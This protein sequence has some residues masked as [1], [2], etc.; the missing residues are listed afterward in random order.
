LSSEVVNIS[1]YYTQIEEYNRVFGDNINLYIIDFDDLVEKES[2]TVKKCLDFM[3][4]DSSF[5]SR[6]AG[7]T[8]NETRTTL[9][10]VALGKLR[11]MA[12]TDK[13]FQGRRRRKIQAMV[14]SLLPLVRHLSPASDKIR[15]SSSERKEII[16]L[17]AED[18]RS[19]QSEHGFDTGKW[20]F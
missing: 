16:D 4:L 14:R 6:A 1:R 19:F 5:K 11:G 13:L 8:F 10:D 17:L 18:M 3:G 15:L 2:E 9:A 20:G 7:E 12:W